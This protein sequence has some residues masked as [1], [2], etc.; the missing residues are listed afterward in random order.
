MFTLSAKRK[1]LEG[2]SAEGPQILIEKLVGLSRKPQVL[3]LECAL[4]NGVCCRK[5]GNRRA[6]LRHS[7]QSWH[8]GDRYT[9]ES[10]LVA[11]TQQQLSNLCAED[12]LGDFVKQSRVLGI[13]VGTRESTG[14]ITIPGDP[15]FFWSSAGQ[16]KSL[17]L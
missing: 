17:P 8:I 9:G 14:L 6:P 15:A 5:Q 1:E 16:E 12:S 3:D 7:K 4:E 2:T 11:S 10:H 13:W